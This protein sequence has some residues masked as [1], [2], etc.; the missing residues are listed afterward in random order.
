MPQYHDT[1]KH[2]I[3]DHS[4]VDQPEVLG[5]LGLPPVPFPLPE[6]LRHE[7]AGEEPPP[8]QLLYWLQCCSADPG[9]DWLG[10]EYAM[11][12]LLQRV[13]SERDIPSIEPLG[14][15]VSAITCDQWWFQLSTVDPGQELVTLERDGYM[16]AALAPNEE[17]RLAIATYRPLDAA[18]LA[19]LTRLAAHPHP[20]YGVAMRVNNWELAVDTAAEPDNFMATEQGGPYLAH[21]P[22]GLGGVMA[23]DIQAQLP[24]TLTAAQL[25][26]FQRHIDSNGAP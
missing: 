1:L 15:A 2:K 23:D 26:V 19:L 7:A 25:Q 11:Q 3:I 12:R 6:K 17:H 22:M 21:W 16:L 24:A 5:R 9:A 20:R 14:P 13:A 4:T 18:S 8:A 10:L